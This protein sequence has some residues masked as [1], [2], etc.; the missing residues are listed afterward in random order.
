ME[1]DDDNEVD[2]GAHNNEEG[3]DFETWSDVIV[4]ADGK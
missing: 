3:A 2:D 1:H 4:E